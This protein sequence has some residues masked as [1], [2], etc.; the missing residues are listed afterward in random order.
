MKFIFSIITIFGCSLLATSQDYNLS[1]IGYLNVC[2]D[3]STGANDIWGWVDSEGNEYALVGLNNG[4]SIV[5]IS[6]PTNPVEVFFEPGSNSVWRDLKTWNN[7]AYVT[8][9]A[10]EGLLIIDLSTLPS[11]PNLST[12]YFTPIGTIN[13]EPLSAHNLYI[14]ENG[15]CYLFGANKGNRGVLMLDLTKDPKAPEEIGKVDNWYAHDG[16]AKNDI[17]YLGNVSDG[18]LSIFDVSDKSN[19]ELL[20]LQVTPSS[21]SHNVWFSDDQNYLYNTDEKSGA[22]ITEYDISDPKNIIETDRIRTTTSN[23]VIPHNTHYVNDYLVTS[24][25]RDGVI[26]HDVS[27]KGNMKEVARYDTSPALS[28]NGFNGCWGVYPFLPSGL[29]I[30]SDIENGLHILQTDASINLVSTNDLSKNNLE[31][32]ISPNPFQNEIF[33]EGSEV[34]GST[35]KVYSLLGELIETNVVSSQNIQFNTS[36]SKGLY[37]LSIENGGSIIHQQKLMKE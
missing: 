12:T 3:H 6:D 28:G 10:R 29:I 13:G 7:H 27:E 35:Y 16:V 37:I 11:N 32:S 24:Y 33:L 19:P 23:D 4:T 15:I 22:Y 20:G 26:I 34:I 21:F 17:L 31:I 30:A 2:A 8:T 1:Q 18:H 9:E 25:Y 5:D 14:D 36:F